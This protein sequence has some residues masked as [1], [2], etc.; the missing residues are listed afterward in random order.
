MTNQI[1]TGTFVE[2]EYTKWPHR[3]HYSYGMRTL[4]EDSHGVWGCC[5]IGDQVQKA[6]APSFVRSTPLLF[7]IPRT[8]CW[9]ATWYPPSEEQLE[10][11]IDIN[12]EPTWT[13]NTVSMTDLDFDVLRTATVPSSS[14]MRA[15]LMTTGS[16]TTIHPTSSH[17]PGERPRRPSPLHRYTPNPSTEPGVPGTP[18]YTASEREA[19]SEAPISALLI[20]PDLGFSGVRY[21]R[22]KG[23]RAVDTSRSPSRAGHVS[24]DDVLPYPGGGNQRRSARLLSSDDARRGP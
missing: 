10:V 4:G 5:E 13:G 6:G 17:S 12:T 18:E 1:R 16:P 14:S 11:Y 15:S 24:P 21:V 19:D 3:K 8:G 22:L 9:S 23:A 7:L 2:I 20:S